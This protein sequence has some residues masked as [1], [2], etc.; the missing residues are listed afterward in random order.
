MPARSRGASALAAAALAVLT[1][2]GEGGGVPIGGD[3]GTP[4]T[5]RAGTVAAVAVATG[6]CLDG[7]V[8]GVA[9]RREIDSARVVSCEGDHA[10]EVYATF[11]LGRPELDLDDDE[12]LTAYPGRAPVVSAAEEGCTDRIE[13]LVEEPEVFGLIALWPSEDSWATGDRAVACAVF[14]ADGASFDRRQ[15]Q[16]N[17]R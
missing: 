10:F 5:V 14:S 11:D 6:D 2:C 17:P 1:G 13:A 15:L 4:V 7:I 16:P 12:D 3:D 9:E 8:I